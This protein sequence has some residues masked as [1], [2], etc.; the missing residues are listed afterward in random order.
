MG[1]GAPWEQSH[2]D[3]SSLSPL[4]AVAPQERHCGCFTTRHPV[5]LVQCKRHL[6]I[7]P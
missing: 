2:S 7:S 5:L 4:A 3:N 1:A 6:K